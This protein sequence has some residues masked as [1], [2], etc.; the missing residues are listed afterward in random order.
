MAERLATAYAA[1][2]GMHNFQ[3]SSA[4]TQAVV[5]HPIHPS[6]V[7]ILEQLGG[8]ASNFAARQLT[9]RMAAEADLILTMT[10]IHRET[11]LELAPHQLN[12]TFTLGE[13][14][15]LTS[16]LNAQTITDLAPLRPRLA[17]HQPLDIPDPIGQAKSVFATAGAHIANLLP[18]ILQLCRRS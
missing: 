16:E 18:P 12:R 14:F 4:G 13:A 7:P 8:D 11:V 6:A 15:Q 1:R 5:G 10:K 3:T 2:S 17:A 9:S